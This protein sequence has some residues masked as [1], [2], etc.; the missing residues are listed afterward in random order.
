MYWGVF[1]SY[2]FYQYVIVC[3]SVM[4]ICLVF[5]SFFFIF[6]DVHKG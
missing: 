1:L 5:F 4:Y 2:F 6:L 3:E